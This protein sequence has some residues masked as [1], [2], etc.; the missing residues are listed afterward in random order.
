MQVMKKPRIP[1]D[2]DVAPVLRVVTGSRLHGFAHADSDFDAWVVLPQARDHSETHRARTSFQA[3]EKPDDGPVIDT[4]YVG[5]TTFLHYCA[6]GSPQALETLY[7]PEP[8]IDLIGP[9]FRF[10]YRVNPNTMRA[11]YRRQ[12]IQ[13]ILPRADDVKFRR[14]GFRLALNLDTALRHG[15]F[16]PTLSESERGQVASAAANEHR[17]VARLEAA[18]DMSLPQEV[19]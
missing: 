7:A 1:F 9:A 17:F 18:L 12:I 11:S 5:L 3:I 19:Q 16:N 8:E 2:L 4:T 15:W 6:M 14:H 10:G 13:N